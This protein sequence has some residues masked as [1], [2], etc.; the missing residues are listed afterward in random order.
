MRK[1]LLIISCL[2]LLITNVYSKEIND[3]NKSVQTMNVLVIE[4]DPILYSITNKSLYPNNSGHPK[5]SEWFGFDINASISEV[6]K[7]IEDTSHGYIKVN[8]IREYLNEFPTYKN[9]ITLLNGTSAYKFDEETYI[10]MGKTSDPYHGNWFQMIYTDRFKAID[11]VG[12]GNFN[13]D[14]LIQKFDLI[15]RRN[16]KEFD[17]VW[18][19]NTS[20][21]GSYETM[22]VGSKPYWIN[23]SP[24][25]Y[26]C[27]NFIIAGFETARRDSAFHSLGHFTENVMRN[28]FGQSKDIYAQ[29]VYSI[30]SKED[31]NK[32]NLWEKY[33]LTSYNNSNSRYTSVG[34]THFT[35]NSTY[36]YDYQNNTTVYSNYREWMNYPNVTGDSFESVNYNT[37]Y[38]SDI[39]KSVINSST[40][41][42]EPDRLYQ[43]FWFSLLP[44]ITG[45]TADGYVNNWWKYI[46]SLD[47]VTSLSTN[48]I[49]INSEVG[50]PVYVNL[51]LNYYS[52]KRE[53]LT[54]LEKGNNI[55]SNNPSVVEFKN[56][57]LYA[58]S[59][60][61]AQIKVNYDGKSLVYALTV[62]DNTNNNSNTGNNNSGN[63]NTGNNNSGNT[64]TGNNSGNTNSG[65]NNNNNNTSNNNN[66]ENNNASN[67]SGNTSN[68]NS[69]STLA[70]NPNTGNNTPDNGSS[71]S[72]PT[73]H[74]GSNQASNGQSNVTSNYNLN[75]TSDD[76]YFTIIDSDNPS[77][78]V[79][80]NFIK[81]GGS[82]YVTEDYTFSG[83]SS[84]SFKTSDYI[85]EDDE[86]TDYV[87]PF[88]DPEAT[89]NTLIGIFVV[90]IVMVGFG[91]LSSFMK[92]P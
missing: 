79:S 13:Y 52:G 44:H 26:N 64:N 41:N 36:G 92:R 24:L 3:P 60:G 69:S 63:T 67:N 31:Y 20:P 28:I 59:A 39:N 35:F 83:N 66:Q 70:P 57:V 53:T 73:T 90:T 74:S 5:V 56:G 49:Y 17:Q 78:E 23:G 8:L 27:D 12:A 2:L 6:K 29:N 32:L 40:Q 55:Q 54:T 87:G 48:N 7:D 34:N 25:T 15:N 76:N 18:I 47:Y 30:N 68:N 80:T 21:I 62:V 45:Y 10:S 50:K 75:I 71:S 84:G 51:T 14:Y 42:K 86:E 61:T 85:S 65:N 77:S 11:S 81:G 38:N 22:M 37:I 43:R 33:T 91:Y 58:K 88:N 16:R 89:K 82:E 9:A 19:F 4:I 46:Y 72:N 1:V